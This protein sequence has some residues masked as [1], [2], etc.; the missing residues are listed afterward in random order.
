VILDR[1][2]EQKEVAEEVGGWQSRIIVAYIFNSRGAGFKDLFY[3]CLSFVSAIFSHMVVIHIKH[4]LAN[5]VEK[6][7]EKEFGHVLVGI[8]KKI[9]MPSKIK[10]PTLL[11][12]EEK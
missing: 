3:H 2:L 8:W 10:T 4:Q 5:G 1:T 6:K 12:A 11:M 7:S 9:T